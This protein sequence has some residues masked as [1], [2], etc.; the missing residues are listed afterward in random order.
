MAAGGIAQRYWL[1][2]DS[3][4]KGSAAQTPRH[5]HSSDKQPM[6]A[7]AFF[8]RIKAQVLQLTAA[9]PVGKVCTFQSMGEHLAVVPRH[10]AYILSQLEDGDKRSLPWHRVVSSDGSLGTPKTG[11]DGT[12]QAELLR[13]EGLLISSNRIEPD[14]SR[15]FIAAGALESG[16]PKQTRPANAPSPTLVSTRP[17]PR[18]PRLR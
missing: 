10:V 5:N 15:V 18:A 1:L 11:A 14:F 16:L 4:R 2:D 13:D 12:T 9:I 7:S 6:P 17:K 8:A 3:D